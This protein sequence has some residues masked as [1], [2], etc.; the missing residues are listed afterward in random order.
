VNVGKKKG[1]RFA[2][3]EP[4]SRTRRAGVCVRSWLIEVVVA[5]VNE[6]GR[7]DL[8]NAWS[9]NTMI[10]TVLVIERQDGARGCAFLFRGHGADSWEKRI[11]EKKNTHQSR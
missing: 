7:M 5:V 9:G 1:K 6:A 4:Q 11:Y 8:G 3:R 2:I 10:R